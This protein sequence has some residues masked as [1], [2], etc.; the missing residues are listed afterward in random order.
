LRLKD[1]EG[2]K[3]YYW[4]SRESFVRYDAKKDVLLVSG[5]RYDGEQPLRHT[6]GEKQAK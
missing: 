1:Q 4:L 3:D 2:Q 6:K 5:D